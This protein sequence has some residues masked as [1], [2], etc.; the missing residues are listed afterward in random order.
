MTAWAL[1]QI[2]RK[3]FV[4]TSETIPKK[5]QASIFFNEQFLSF[6]IIKLIYVSFI[7]NTIS[8]LLANIKNNT[9]T[10]FMATFCG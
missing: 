5:D 4:L 3:Y 10:L 2:C 7:E 6:L 1:L 9:A 8:Q